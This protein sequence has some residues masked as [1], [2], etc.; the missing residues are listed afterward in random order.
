LNVINFTPGKAAVRGVN[1]GALIYAEGQLGTRAAVGFPISVDHVGVLGIKNGNGTNGA[2]V[3]G[4]NRDGNVENYG[5][6]FIA[7]GTGNN[8][9]ALFAIADGASDENF[10][11]LL[12][13]RTSVESTMTNSTTSDGPFTVGTRGGMHLS[14]DNNEVQSY[15]DPVT[16]GGTLFLNYMGGN[17][18]LVSPFHNTHGDVGMGSAFHYDGTTDRLGLGTVAP[19]SPLDVHGEASEIG[20]VVNVQTTFTGSADVRGI[21]V[22]SITDPGWGVGIEGYGGYVGVVGAADA[23]TYAANAYGLYGISTG[24]AGGRIGVYGAALGISGTN[25]NYGVYGETSGAAT[26]NYAVYASGDLAYTGSLINLSDARFKQ[27]VEPVENALELIVQ[28]KP[29]SYT[30]RTEEFD[31]MGLGEGQRYGFV[32]Q[33]LEQVLPELVV[34]AVHPGRMERTAD[35]PVKESKSI[36][37]KA[38]KPLEMIPLIVAAIQEL[39]LQSFDPAPIQ[40][41]LEELRAE[42]QVLRDALNNLRDR[43]DEIDVVVGDCC[44][45]SLRSASTAVSSASGND[46]SLGQNIPNPS[47]GS[48]VIPYFLPEGAKNATL[49]IF[50]V[51]GELIHSYDLET[52]G[53]GQISFSDGQLSAGNYVYALFIDEERIDSKQMVVTR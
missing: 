25:V 28:L 39:Q 49:R 30:M 44:A 26:N 27:S 40:R 5:G 17:V 7:D 50:D 29:R 53:V 51:R 12:A 15:N 3:Y 4:W 42:N 6:V 37:F 35:G 13:G 10:A 23:T 38:I 46:A 9:Y 52:S 34:D 8:N 45:E 18:E 32:A 21:L 22:H 48:T 2:A 47:D 41:E 14:L 36:Q 1:E 43:L 20:P 19:S 16:P 31:F 24:S 11:A 33:E